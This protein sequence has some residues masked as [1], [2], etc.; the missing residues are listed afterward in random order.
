LKERE[1]NRRK[2]DQE[3]KKKDFERKKEQLE[4]R[5]A[6]AQRRKENEERRKKEQEEK[7]KK[8]E[9]K[10]ADEKENKDEDTEMK[11]DETPKE[12]G[13]EKK[14]AIE[15]AKEEKTE[16]TAEKT[17]ESEPEKK[18]NSTELEKKEEKPLEELVEPVWEEIK[19]EDID[20]E[21]PMN[22][23][24]EGFVH[25][26][27]L[28]QSVLVLGPQRPETRKDCEVL[29]LI[30]LPGAGKTHWAFKKCEECPEKRYTVLGT[31]FLLDKMK[32]LG[33]TRKPGNNQMRWEKLIELCNRGIQTLNDIAAKRR[34]NYILDQP[35]V[36]T[37]VQRRKM[38]VFGDFKRV[39][40]IVVP[41]EEEYKKRFKERIDKEGKDLPDHTINELKANISLPELEYKWFDEIL[42]SD[43]EGE[44]AKEAIGKENELGKKE[45]NRRRRNDYGR[46]RDYGRNNRDQRW[47]PRDRWGPPSG[48]RGPPIP[49]PGFRRDFGYDNRD[50]RGGWGQDNWMNNNRSRGY[51][52]APPPRPGR[53]DDRDRDR[54]DHHNRD[55]RDYSNRSGGSSSNNRNDRRDDRGSSKN[56]SSKDWNSGANAAAAGQW[57]NNW[58]NYCEFFLFYIFL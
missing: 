14:E 7:K 25:L 26:T 12:N 13:E 17:E 50:R 47:A 30:G 46:G 55:R 53:R 21:T 57:G 28:D 41:E 58:N 37:S 19:A 56:Q 35:H 34:R 36:Y 52:G 45:L 38:R 2:N 32:I 6:D 39:A 15:D 8:D 31:K 43:L 24:L 11:P 4:R 44:Q 16:E 33:E 3:R 49:P 51:G 1:F 29:M 23:Q 5:K 40:V 27:T 48:Q 42:Y 22:N 54:R 18:E 20:A 9:E 10:P